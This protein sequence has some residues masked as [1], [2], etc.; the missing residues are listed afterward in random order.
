MRRIAIIIILFAASIFCVDAQPKKIEIVDSLLSEMTRQDAFSGAVLVADN[1]TI[2]LS[3]GYGYSDRENR[4][5]NTPETRFDIS[6]TSTIFTATAVTYL[7]Q[8]GK[9]KFTDTIS[10]YLKGLPKGNIITIQQILTH[11]AG[12]DFFENA[13][14]FNYKKI[15]SC[16]D[17]IPFMRT[18]PLLYNPGDSC[19]Y[20]SGDLIVL[21]AVIEKISGMNFPEFIETTFAKPL[22]LTNTGFT[23]YFTLDESQR[24][25]SIGYHKTDSG[26]KKN[27]YSYDNGFIPL[28]AGGDWSC[29]A[30]LYKFDKAIFSFKL[31]REDYVK[32]MTTNYTSQWE[33][34]H[35]G[36]IWII[37]HKKDYSVI[38]HTGTS[39][40]WNAVNNYYPKQKYTVIILTNLGSVDVDMLTDKIEKIIF[41]TN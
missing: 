15:K 17:I 14:G 39:S 24:K 16:T 2:L 41:D 27:E 30:D 22:G 9:L 12:F 26:Y 19:S 3:K 18:L 23:P 13:K 10:K 11:S 40:G 34:T 21:G 5:K 1:S 37:T 36:F 29:I 25:Y 6:T 8:Q 20:S 35:F 4:I 38:G 33:N 28:S 31:I 32:Q 7:A